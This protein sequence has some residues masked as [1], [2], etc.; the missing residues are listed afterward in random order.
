MNKLLKEGDLVKTY[1]H[2]YK[3]VQKIK[4]S[5][6]LF[7]MGGDYKHSIFRMIQKGDMI[8][9]LLVTGRHGILLNDLSTHITHTSRTGPAKSMI[10]DKCMLTAAYC[11]QFIQEKE[12]KQ[13]TIYH[14]ALEGDERRYGVYANGALMETWDNKSNDVKMSE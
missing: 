9:D 3:A 10:D 14:F 6:Q 5:T 12:V 1:K 7:N 11:N 8:D 13:Y 2:G 4:T